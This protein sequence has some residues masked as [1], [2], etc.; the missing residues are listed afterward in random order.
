MPAL[1]SGRHGPCHGQQP[2]KPE[3]TEELVNFFRATG[4]D[5]E[6][7]DWGRASERKKAAGKATKPARQT[8]G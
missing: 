6:Q 1:A 5:P 3:I 2:A 4:R 8:E 7:I